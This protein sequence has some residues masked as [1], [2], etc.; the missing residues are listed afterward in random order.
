MN[1][2]KYRIGDKVE[3]ICKYKNDEVTG[4]I[5]NIRQANLN[6]DYSIRYQ[7]YTDLA[8]VEWVKEQDIFQKIK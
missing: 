6:W 3:Y 2:P 1:K 5:I 7:I 8:Y 4:E